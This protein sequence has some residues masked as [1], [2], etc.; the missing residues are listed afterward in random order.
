MLQI[1]DDVY[2]IWMNLYMHAKD[3]TGD[4]DKNGNAVFFSH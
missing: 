4:Y 3:G 2:F 1:H